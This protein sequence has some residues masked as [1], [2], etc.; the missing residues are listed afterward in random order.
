MNDGRPH[1]DDRDRLL[2]S[3]GRRINRYNFNDDSRGVA[4][5]EAVTEARSLLELVRNSPRDSQVQMAVAHLFWSRVAVARRTGAGGSELELATAVA[6]F[7]AVY[8]NHADHVP[9]E[10]R[11]VL[12]A[13]GDAKGRAS[14]LIDQAGYGGGRRALD[15][16]IE[17]LRGVIGFLGE[18]DP[19]LPIPL[20]ELAVALNGRYVM[21]LRGEDIVEAV[22]VIGRAI[23]LS[24]P[25]D[26]EA[27]NRRHL[28]KLL[29]LARYDQFGNLADL[30]ESIRLGHQL[31]NET[32]SD[33]PIRARIM[34]DFIPIYGRRYKRLQAIA[35]LDDGIRYGREGL[36]APANRLDSFD[37]ASSKDDLSILLRQRGVR[38][39]RV[40]DLEEAVLLSRE[41]VAEFPA[42]L[43][44]W[45][46]I[47]NGLAQAL[48]FAGTATGDTAKLHEAV[49]TA[50]DVLRVATERHHPGI[51]GFSQNVG[52]SY[53][54]IAKIDSSIL[55]LTRAV[56]YLR[57]AVAGFADHPDGRAARTD[58]G[59][60]LAALAEGA[61]NPAMLDEAILHHRAAVGEG[62]DD[63]AVAQ[64]RIN[65]AAALRTRHDRTGAVE[66]HA[67]A[68]ELFRSV[69]GQETVAV[70][71]RLLAAR[72]W[73]ILETRVENWDDASRA[74][75]LAVD[76]LTGASAPNLARGDQ[77]RWLLGEPGLVAEAVAA[78]LQTG[79]VDRAAE[80]FEQGRGVLTSYAL[81][82]RTDVSRLA[83][84][85]PVLA[86]TFVR[87]RD[88]LDGD[89]SDHDTRHLWAS[90]WHELLNTIR[91]RPSFAGFL[92]PMSAGQMQAAAAD[93]AIV[94]VNVGERR[95]DALVV[96]TDAI[97]VVPLPL[98]RESMTLNAATF[99]MSLDMLVDGAG[100]SD[101]QA[102]SANNRTRQALRWAWQA[103]TGPVLAYLGFTEPIYGG[104][105]PR[106]WWMPCA[107]LNFLPL[108]AAFVENEEGKQTSVLDLVVCSYT[109]TVKSLLRARTRASGIRRP[110]GPL[111]VGMADTPG[112]SLLPGVLQEA[113]F[114][115]SV[116]PTTVCLI[117]GLATREAV[118]RGL[119]N[120]PWVHISCHGHSD[121]TDPSA[122]YLLVA[123][124][125]KLPLLE[126]AQRR[127]DGEF[128]FL[129]ACS[130]GAS[131]LAL[132]DE[133]VH[134]AGAFQLAGYSHVIAAMWPIHDSVALKITREVYALIS[135]GATS[136]DHAAAI[137][138]NAV[139][140]V[141]ER[142]PDEPV[143]WASFVHIGP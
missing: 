105:R 112:Q 71:Q 57:V 55:H 68:V 142:Y 103:V 44:D 134:L 104:K 118:L 32:T 62:I 84:E 30:E 4:D 110:T 6:H 87:L 15:D 3:L 108:H 132:A 18:E 77:E 127:I 100:L 22:E 101:E 93:G 122:S 111:V 33:D 82:L 67:E 25:D 91:A 85:D 38:T 115:Q 5:D 79:D 131:G 58:L 48:R 80:L 39:G 47:L 2:R 60:A 120:H 83:D 42:E 54:E 128:A 46:G 21:T 96:R 99:V 135:P 136:V 89:I 139:L 73:G 70:G 29:L 56:E 9:E 26:E 20:A 41:A 28:R 27:S 16:A 81:D 24:H 143:L 69:A 88:A 141:R 19:T 94:M 114:I 34:L 121:R 140:K 12:D 14:I 129:S 72:S 40:A 23:D 52:A 13:V 123:G 43:F 7:S 1:D 138:H 74:L 125:D 37:R 59:N 107:L 35:D 98:T 116:F 90:Q 117:D 64:F 102:E 53:S 124:A 76:L 49:T 78:T 97:G 66:D 113:Q 92:L 106:L 17:I 51:P 45:V 109:P 126:I 86:D 61:E 63:P 133:S 10:V 65:L 50:L 137:L 11:A 130:T 75:G 119:R 95:S 36:L 31:L 8:D